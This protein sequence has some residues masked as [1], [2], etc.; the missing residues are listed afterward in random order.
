MACPR[1][2]KEGVRSASLPRRE[3][4]VGET[5]VENERKREREE[6]G[7]GE[8]NERLPKKYSFERKKEKE[9]ARSQRRFASA[10]L[11]LRE[12]M[13]RRLFSEMDHFKKV[14]Y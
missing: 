11:F 9:L 3:V 6:E 5:G 1:I 13:M 7:T 8:E 4:A 12:K 14:D 10:S 2:L